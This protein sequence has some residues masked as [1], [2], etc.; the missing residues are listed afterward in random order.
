[1]GFS[2]ILIG[3]HGQD[4]MRICSTRKRQQP[5]TG[6]NFD[7]ETIWPHA[8]NLWRCKVDAA[9]DRAAGIARPYITTYIRA[10]GMGKQDH[11]FRGS[12][13]PQTLDL[14]RSDLGDAIYA[15]VEQSIFRGA[16]IAII[17]ITTYIRAPGMGKQDHPLP[18]VVYP[19]NF[20]SPSIRPRGRYICKNR[21][22]D[23]YMY[24][25]RSANPVW[26]T[27]LANP[28]NTGIYTYIYIWIP[29]IVAIGWCITS[30]VDVS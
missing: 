22:I 28:A 24:I 29:L 23:L 13:T 7:S 19:R 5:A 20:G 21:K 2:C 18:G 26:R 15:K 1:M 25:Y 3:E 12:Y 10:P 17:Y 16:G 6:G 9:N 30:P 27:G 4:T 14:H 11:P 8:I